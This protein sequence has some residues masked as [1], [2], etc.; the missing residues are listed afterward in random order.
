MILDEMKVKEDIVYDKVTGN[1][2][3]FCN[4][5]TINDELLQAECD[6]TGSVTADLLFPIV[7]EGIHI[8]ENTG[9]K[10]IA[11]G[12]SKQEIL[13]DAWITERWYCV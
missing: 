12:K 4:L 11:W 13:Q 9:L 3:G 5:R 2:I 7:W 10:V 8:V 6:T 1:V